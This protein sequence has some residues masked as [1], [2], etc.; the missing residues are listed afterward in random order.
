ML[1]GAS[2][3]P[4]QEGAVTVALRVRPGFLGG[5]CVPWVPALGRSLCADAHSQLRAGGPRQSW[6]P[7]LCRSG[8]LGPEPQLG[9]AMGGRATLWGPRQEA[10]PRGGAE[11]IMREEPPL[12]AWP[13][14]G[15]AIPA[16]LFPPQPL[17]LH[18][19]TWGLCLPEGSVLLPPRT[20]TAPQPYC[21]YPAR[22]GTLDC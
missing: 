4:I 1:G 19:P 10:W 7:G 17:P 3:G 6:G 18:K 5:H 21:V 20:S 15:A 9:A 8:C 14:G 2:G 16:G 22:Q 12:E 13:R 11:L